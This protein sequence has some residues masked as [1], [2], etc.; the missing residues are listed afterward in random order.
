MDSSSN[1]GEVG[2]PPD[3]AATL[4]TAMSRERSASARAES[5]TRHHHEQAEGSSY[6][7][8]LRSLLCPSRLAALESSDVSPVP[9]N[10]YSFFSHIISIR[11]RGFQM[12]AVPLTSLFIWDLAWWFIF[13]KGLIDM[14]GK[15]QDDVAS[16][17][18]LV[19]P[20]LT[21]L[22]FL[23]TFRLGRAAVRW[24]EVRR[25]VRSGKFSMHSV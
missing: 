8:T 4:A 25:V 24:W 6:E 3:A 7:K 17:A 21:P 2:L 1:T 10:T 18:G 12:L 15:F 20:L 11:G 9:Y 16:L 14:E 13:S 19:D 22:S 5:C 23:L